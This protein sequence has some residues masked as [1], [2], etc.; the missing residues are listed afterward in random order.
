MPLATAHDP[1][2]LTVGELAERIWTPGGREGEPDIDLIGIRRGETTSEVLIG[3]GEELGDERHQ[4]IAAIAAR[5]RPP[6]PPGCSSG[7]RRAAPARTRARSGWRP[8]AGRGS[9]PRTSGTHPVAQSETSRA[10]PST[11]CSGTCWSTWKPGECG[12]RPVLDASDGPAQRARSAWR[13]SKVTNVRPSAAARSAAARW[14]A[15]S[16][17]TPVRSA[18]SAARAHV[19]SSSSTISASAQS[20]AKGSAPGGEPRSGNACC[21]ARRPRPRCARPKPIRDRPRIFRGLVAFRL[22]DVQLYQRSIDVEA[23]SSSRSSLMISVVGRFGLCRSLDRRRLPLP[24]P[25]PTLADS[26]LDCRLRRRTERRLRLAAVGHADDLPVRRPIEVVRQ[27][28]LELRE[29]R[30]RS[31]SH[32]STAM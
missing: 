2:V 6:R 4:G 12:I 31:Y 7:S 22:A 14:S 10:A 21:S 29:H 8:C 16:V 23:H 5:S 11:G 24:G 17:L 15:S 1:V 30:P 18:I 19:A 9:S 32:I 20:L 26:S 3:P 28:R 27:L 13:R 25:D